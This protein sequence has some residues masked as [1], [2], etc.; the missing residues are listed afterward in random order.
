MKKHQ[1][2]LACTAVFI[3]LFYNESVGINI[4]IFGVLLTLLISYFFQE[5]FVDRSHLVLVMTSILSC[6]GFCMVWRRGIFFCFSI[7]NPLFTIQNPRWR[8]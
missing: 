6:F 7:I 5:K 2:I 4:S 8:T 1:I 3:L